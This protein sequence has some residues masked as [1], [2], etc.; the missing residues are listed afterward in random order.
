[1]SWLEG[2]V[3]ESYCLGHSDSD[4][5]CMNETHFISRLAFARV[6]SNTVQGKK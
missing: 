2:T 4:V 1:M 3:E 5:R 6:E